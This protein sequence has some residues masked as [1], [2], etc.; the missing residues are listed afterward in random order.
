MEIHQLRYFLAVARTSNFSRAAEQCHVSQP[1]LSQQIMKLEAEL[2]ERLFA[3][4][5]RAVA[6]TPAGRRLL[7]HAGRVLDELELARESVSERGAVVRGRVRLGS[8]PT[9]APYHLPGR[10]RAFAKTFPEVEVEVHEDTTAQLARAVV[11]NEIDLALVS[12]PLGRRDLAERP[13]FDEPLFLALPA[14]HR[15]AGR[16]RLG[17]ADVERETFILMQEGHCL[18]GQTLAFCHT[19]GFAPRVSFRSAQIETVRA[20]VAAGWGVSV[21][22]RMACPAKTGADD[23]MRYVP[24]TGLS[25]AVGF[26]SHAQRSPARAVR[27][28]VDFFA[29]DAEDAR[30]RPRV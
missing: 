29:K 14:G 11:A 27:A 13:L 26:I 15:L 20:F 19:Q 12:L 7:G 16:R 21:V 9:V 2:G 28:L 8:L 18:A 17:L 24:L 10:L 3:R 6:L 4:N 5:R 1:S 25:R 30:R 22:P 23:P